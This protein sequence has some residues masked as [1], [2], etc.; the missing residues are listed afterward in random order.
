MINTPTSELVYITK[1]G[2]ISK[3]KLFYIGMSLLLSVSF[4]SFVQFLEAHQ[5]QFIE[6]V[7]SF[8]P[9]S[10][11]SRLIDYIIK[12][13]PRLSREV[14]E[15]LAHSMIVASQENRIPINLMIGLMKVESGFDQYAISN[16]GALGFMQVMP[17]WHYDKIGKAE[18]KNIYSPATNVK[19]GSTVLRDCM[20]KFKQVDNALQCYNGSN[21]DPTKKYANK[22]FG[23]VPR[24]I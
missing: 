20:N 14:A 2:F 9:T 5:S 17:R 7:K 16:A 1:F 21:N 15:E 22:V 11:E 23:A 19:V 12:S 8:Q 4:F 6:T 10:F 3:M 13:N 18:D 24:A